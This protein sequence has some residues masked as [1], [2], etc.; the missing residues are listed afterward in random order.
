MVQRSAVFMR[1]LC[2]PLAQAQHSDTRLL[3]VLLRRLPGLGTTELLQGSIVLGLLRAADG[4]HAGNSL[5][6]E[7]STVAM[8]G[9]LVGNTLVD[10][11][12]T[13]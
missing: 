9:G 4:T 5:F 6:A 10:T 11:E 13:P 2:P 3:Q 8:L 12:R 1:V 7:V